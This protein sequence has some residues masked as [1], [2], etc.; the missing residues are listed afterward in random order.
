MLKTRSTEAVNSKGKVCRIPRGVLRRCSSP[1]PRQWACRC[2]SQVCDAWPVWRHTY[3]YLPSHKAS[4]VLTPVPNCPSC[5]APLKP[6]GALQ[7]L[8]CIVL[9]VMATDF[10]YRPTRVVP[11]QRP[12]NG[13]CCCCCHGN[14]STRVNKLLKAIIRRQNGSESNLRVASPNH[15]VVW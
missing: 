15:R 4:C 8:Y 2:I 12:L 11:D 1:F 7:I 9:Y 3:S 13:R 5:P 14:R 10:W 6:H